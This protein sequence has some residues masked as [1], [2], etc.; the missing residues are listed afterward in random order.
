MDIDDSLTTQPSGAQRYVKEEQDGSFFAGSKK[1]KKK[2][3]VTS[4]APVVA[5]EAPSQPVVHSKKGRKCG[6]ELGEVFITPRYIL[7]KSSIN[8]R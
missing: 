3:V 4:S 1:T 6:W 8:P 2:A 7:D 5:K